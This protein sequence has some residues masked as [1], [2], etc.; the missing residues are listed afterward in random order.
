MPDL[1]FVVFLGLVM[2]AAS[3]G[4]LFKPGEWYRRLNK[5]SWTPPDIAFPIVWTVLYLMI[6]V[7]GWLV[8]REGSAAALIVWGLQ[9]ILNALWSYLFFG[10]R[11]MDLALA[12]VSLLWLSVAGFI[13][14]AWPLS[15]TAA[16]LFAPY[17]VWVTIA[18]NL[19]RTVRK[20]NPDYA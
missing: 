9:L 3:T 19:N 14:L 18:A 6:A 8:W 4:M 11:R 16:L 20:M 12:D 7:A 17:L 1:S 2:V 10:Q 13:I 5:P 15:T